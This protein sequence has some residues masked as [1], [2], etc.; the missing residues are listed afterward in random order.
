VKEN[1][2]KLVSGHH[3]KEY[4]CVASTSTGNTS[5][6]LPNDFRRIASSPKITY[7]GATTAVFDE[8]RPQE[9]ARFDKSS[10]RYVKILG[11]EHDGFTM[12]VNLATST[13]LMTSG[14]S[15]KLH[16]FSTPSA[17][18]SPA[19]SVYCPNPDYLVQGVIADVWEAREDARFQQA[20]AEANLIL[21]NMLEFE[22]T[23]S[24]AAYD[25][26]VRSIDQSRHNFRWGRD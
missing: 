15:I 7:D 20:K 9:E 16:Y 5:V 8:I 4:N 2:P 21:Q 25:R 14:A 18:A 24:E 10:E 12:V 3:Y 11:N 23:P 22:F 6:A 13:G 26:N 1:G 17:H 19:N